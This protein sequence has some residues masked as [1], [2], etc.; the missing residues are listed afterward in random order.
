M[1]AHELAPLFPSATHPA[2]PIAAQILS[3]LRNLTAPGK[4]ND[5]KPEERAALVGVAALIG[6][7]RVQ[8][9]DLVEKSAQKA[10]SVSPAHFRSALAVARRVLATSSSSETS[11]R[12]PTR[13]PR[14]SPSKAE[15]V[16]AASSSSSATPA[17]ASGSGSGSTAAATPV[18]DALSPFQT[19]RKKFRYASSLDLAG[20]SR[21]AHKHSPAQP[22]PLRPRIVSLAAAAADAASAPTAAVEGHGAG[23]NAVEEDDDDVE[24]TPS[25]RRGPGGALSTGAR[26]KRQREAEGREAFFALRPVAGK[27]GGED[28]DAPGTVVEQEEDEAGFW[29]ADEFGRTAVAGAADLAAKPK[30]ARRDWTYAETKWAPDRAGLERILATVEPTRTARSISAVLLSAGG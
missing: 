5:L 30:R 17:P 16:R 6:C 12:R 23:V 20:L 8:S 7:E 13:S 4:G 18:P 14:S 19:P 24:R 29:R 27:V 26:E 28:V 21:S 3:T 9:K 1:S 15:T 10:C 2:L 11:P 25:K 22:S